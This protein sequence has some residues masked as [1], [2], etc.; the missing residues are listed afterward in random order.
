[1]TEMSDFQKAF[2]SRGTGHKLFTQQEFDQAMTLAQAEIMAVAIETSKQAVMIEREECAK[3][4]D[5]AGQVELAEKI[6]NRLKTK[7]DKDD[8]ANR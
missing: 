8:K 4:V 2:L 5:E 6:R 7:G 3:I 1:M